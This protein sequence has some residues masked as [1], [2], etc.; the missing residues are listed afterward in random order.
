MAIISDRLCPTLCKELSNP[1]LMV[2]DFGAF[3]LFN[4]YL[5]PKYSPWQNWA[6]IHPLQAFSELLAAAIA[7]DHLV[8]VAGDLNGRMGVCTALN[9]DPA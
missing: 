1:D 2:L 7:L 8:Y 3:L 6:D 9:G 4:T 5:L